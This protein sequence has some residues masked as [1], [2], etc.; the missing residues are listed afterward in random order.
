MG[1]FVYGKAEEVVEKMS[2]R[3]G[4]SKCLLAT[5]W[6]STALHVVCSNGTRGALSHAIILPSSP[7]RGALLISNPP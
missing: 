6:S 4:K 2:E 5:G 7:R 1:G 3:V